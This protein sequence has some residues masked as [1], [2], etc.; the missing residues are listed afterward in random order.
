MN[1]MA[2]LLPVSFSSKMGYGTGK[3]ADDCFQQKPM[4]ACCFKHG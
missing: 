3:C 2:L 4:T 1:R